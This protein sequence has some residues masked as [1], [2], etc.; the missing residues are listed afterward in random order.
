[1]AA[2]QVILHAVSIAVLDRR[3]VQLGE[4]DRHLAQRALGVGGAEE[5]LHRRAA[6]LFLQ[7]QRQARHV[8]GD[9]RNRDAI[10]GVALEAGVPHPL[11]QLG[12]LLAGIRLVDL[13]DQ[14]QRP[15]ARR[16][17]RSAMRSAARNAACAAA[18]PRSSSSRNAP[19]PGPAAELGAST[20]RIAVG[21][22]ASLRVN[23][24]SVP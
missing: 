20:A 11:H 12:H 14:R 16:Q 15:A 9:F 2:A 17:S 22:L 19:R 23:S 13:A 10:G 21:S 24:L 8:A 4:T 6:D 1:M 7:E 5:I 3:T 18:A